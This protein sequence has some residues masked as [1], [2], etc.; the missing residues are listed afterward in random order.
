MRVFARPRLIGWA[1]LVLIT[2]AARPA[3]ADSSLS[4]PPRLGPHAMPALSRVGIAGPLREGFAAAVTA[5]Y[6]YLGAV[7]D[8]DDTHH[9]A[10]TQIA[11]SYRPVSWLG[12]AL[13]LDGR[14]DHHASAG[15]SDSGWVGDP[16]AIVRATHRL[17]DRSHVAGELSVWLPGNS[18]PSIVLDAAT[19]D[20]RVLYAYKPPEDRLGGFGHLGFRIDNSANSAPDADS[21]SA[22]DRLALGVADA[23]AVLAGAGVSY[24]MAGMLLFGEL[25]WDLYVGDSAPDPLASPLRVGAGAKIPVGDAY[26]IW[27]L[28]EVS[29]GAR[30]EIGPMEPLYPVEPRVRLAVGIGYQMPAN[31]V[32]MTAGTP[33]TGQISGRVETGDGAGIAGAILR[34]GDREVTTFADGTF[35]VDDVPAG[36]VTLDIAAEGYRA[37]RVTASVSENADAQLNVVLDRDLPVGEVRGLVQSF[38]GTPLPARIRITPGDTEVVADTDGRFE[39]ELSPGRYRV[40]ITAAGHAPQHRKI[41]IERNGVTILNVDLRKK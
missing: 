17:S 15:G 22:A 5:G 30:P 12:M 2:T 13:S 1:C 18:A 28:L 34:I 40:E 36:E 25:S 4:V 29:P 19:I 21:L 6:G 35:V 37:S 33:A 16:R 27:G 32:P 3:G 23:N 9:R 7:L 41:R 38:S 20:A 24:Q 14:Y 11:L 26:Q 10:Q 39:I 8:N 31:A